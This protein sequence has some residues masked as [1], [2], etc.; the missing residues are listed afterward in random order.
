[1]L[2]WYTL[3]PRKVSPQKN[4]TLAGQN[5]DTDVHDI[6]CV[7]CMYLCMAHQSRCTLHY[8]ASHSTPGSRPSWPGAGTGGSPAEE[9]VVQLHEYNCMNGCMDG[10][11]NDCMNGCENGCMDDC[12]N[13]CMD[14]CENGC[15]N[16]C[17]NGLQPTLST[18]DSCLFSLMITE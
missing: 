7:W 18:A 12:A 14:D 9:E 3:Y 8:P 10:C 15:M 5:T 1:M 11:E 16:G 2:K 13:G 17:E 4:V 6:V